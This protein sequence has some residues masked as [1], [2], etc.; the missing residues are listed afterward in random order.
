MTSAQLL[1]PGVV[2]SCLEQLPIARLSE[3]QAIFQLRDNERIQNLSQQRVTLSVGIEPCR[4]LI[5]NPVKRG[6]LDVHGFENG[7]ELVIGVH[8]GSSAVNSLPSV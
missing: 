8:Q 2:L 7:A 3:R 6:F 5:G 4:I 1:F